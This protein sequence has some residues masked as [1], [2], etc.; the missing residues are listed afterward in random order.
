MSFRNARTEGLLPGFANCFVLFGNRSGQLSFSQDA[1]GYVRVTDVFACLLNLLENCFLPD[2]YHPL[3]NLGLLIG[4]EHCDEF[5]FSSHFLLKRSHLE[6]E[7]ETDYD[8][9]GEL[10]PPG[11]DEAD[12]TGVSGP[13]SLSPPGL[14]SV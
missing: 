7:R 6:M 14:R 13:E 4:L 10:S 12:E 2:H 9:A 1:Y 3:I 11:K 5:W 8:R